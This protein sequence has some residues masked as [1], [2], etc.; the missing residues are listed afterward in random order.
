MKLRQN[1]TTT[2]TPRRRWARRLAVA[3]GATGALVVGGI[4]AGGSA[5]AATFCGNTPAGGYACIVGQP[6]GSFTYYGSNGEIIYN[7]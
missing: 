7:W 4:F 5:G 2:V 6:D 1:A 3:V